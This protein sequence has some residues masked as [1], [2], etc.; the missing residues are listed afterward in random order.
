MKTD[1][2]EQRASRV[3]L[4]PLPAEWRS[5][6]LSAAKAASRP[7]A[8]PSLSFRAWLTALL[9]PRPQAWAGLAAVWL[10]ILILNAATSDHTAHVASTSHDS[11]QMILVLKD[12]QQILRELIEPA[13]Q[14]T[15]A[16]ASETRDGRPRSQRRDKVVAV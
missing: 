13:Q 7:A 5:Q 8:A 12:Q 14:P 6:I 15:A 10:G 4:K 11:Q 3:P 1:D 2:F 9:W 16:A